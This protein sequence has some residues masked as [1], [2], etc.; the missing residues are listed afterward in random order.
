MGEGVIHSP[1]RTLRSKAR[2]RRA[3]I[4]LSEPFW[5]PAFAGSAEEKHGPRHLSPPV[6]PAKAGTQTLSHR[7]KTARWPHAWSG[8][9]EENKALTQPSPT[10]RGLEQISPRPLQGERV[11]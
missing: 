5:I 3:T 2:V 7:L 9:L 1:L 6:L 11:G 4:R 8:D 10:G